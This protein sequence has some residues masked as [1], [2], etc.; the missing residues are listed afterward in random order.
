MGLPATVTP[1]FLRFRDLSR[2][3]LAHK[4]G[5]RTFLEEETYCA[6]APDDCQSPG[7]ALWNGKG[8]ALLWILDGLDEVV[9]PD[10]RKKVSAWVQRA[11]K[12]RPDDWFLVTCRFAGYFR[13]GIPLGPKFVEFH[14][15]PLDDQ[16]IEQFVRD[17]FAAAYG[18][19]LGQGSRA[20]ER[21]EAD[22]KELLDILERPAYQAGHI[23]EL[24][25]NPLLL[26]ILCIVFH[27]ERKLPTGRAELYAHCVRV[28][29]EYWRRDLYTSDLGTALEP[30]DAD[31]AQTVLARVA[32]WMHQQQDRTSAPLD[33]LAAEAQAGLAQVAPSS[34]LGRDGHAFVE[35]MRD[36]AGILAMEGE[37]HCGFLH[38]SFQEYLAAEH[39]ASEG[40]AKE[41]ASLAIESWWR[42]AAL[43]SLRQSR[44]FCEAF[45]REMLAARI[46]ENHPDLAERCVTESLYFVPAPFVEVLEMK[47]PK[48]AK[49]RRTHDARVAATLR[50]LRDRNDQVPELE[51]ICRRLVQSQ[52]KEVR[53]FAQEILIKKGIEPEVRGGETGVIADSRT[54]ITFVRI[55]AG[56]FLMGSE[57]GRDNEKPVHQVRITQDF[58]LSKYPVT[59]AQYRKFMEDSNGKIKKPDYW[60][61]RRF[62]QPEQPVVG[63]SWEQAVAFCKWA[64]G[65]LPTEAE[66]EYACR[67]GTTTEY[68]FDDSEEL[69]DYAWY[70]KNGGSQT[71]PVG[72]KKP[73]PWGLHDMHG[74]V[75]E[76]C[77][78]WYAKYTD[79]PAVDP[80]GPGKATGRVIRGG[81]WNGSAGRCRSAYRYGRGPGGRNG[82]LGFRVAAV[83]TSQEASQQAS[84][85][86][87]VG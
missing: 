77:A 21:A 47:Q 86:G 37:G 46:A 26:T 16:Q 14:V 81:S 58:L 6:E 48:A 2:K 63:V 69:G 10:A 24:C 56:E 67:A 57:K 59:N 80:R 25:T 68:S 44:M 17:W 15:R 50:L 74:N 27:E 45:F 40:L 78:D 70:N 7:E 11:I 20:T 76:W 3:A 22:S 51:A 8:G 84:G 38:L 53:A 35:R 61:D 30:Y 19:L 9:N 87:S 1:V 71:Q 32:W 18:K 23:R 83:P 33:E 43:L 72:T 13:E 31:A 82:F 29:L 75:W 66:W 5:L 49:A 36:E 60:D 34:G 62:N 52:E 54:G 73:N 79:E 42:E 85:A 39:A 65:R 41:L 28:L 12:N 64:G 55:P 4:N